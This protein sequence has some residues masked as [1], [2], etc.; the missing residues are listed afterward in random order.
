MIQSEWRTT[1]FLF[2][3]ITTQPPSE[4]IGWLHVTSRRSIEWNPADALSRSSND[5]MPSHDFIQLDERRNEIVPA[6]SWDCDHWHITRS[7]SPL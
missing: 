3:G 6:S 5:G 7:A 1:P 2:R 4:M